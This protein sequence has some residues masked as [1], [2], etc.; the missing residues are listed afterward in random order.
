MKEDTR[1]A[2]DVIAEVAQEVA[3]LVAS[4]DLR[5]DKAQCALRIATILIGY[6]GIKVND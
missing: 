2:A 6:H 1:I 5:L 4:K 3:R